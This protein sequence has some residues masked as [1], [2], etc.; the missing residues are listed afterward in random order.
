MHSTTIAVDLAKSVFEVA[1][2]QRPGKVETRHRLSRGQFSRF[3]AE[4]AP[5]TV[6]MEACGTAHFWGRE[7]QARGH[8]VVLLPPHAVRPYVTRNKTDGADAKGLLEALRNDDVRP[9]PV[10]SVDQH[11]LASLHRL[12]S[13]WMATRTARLNTLRGLLRELGFVIPLGARQVL[14]RVGELVSDADSGLPDALRPVLAETAR[15][16]RELE[17][18]VREVERSLETM[19]RGSEILVRLRTIPGVGLLTATA[20]GAF[21][22][23][24]ARFPSGRHFASYLGLTPRESSSG[25]RRRLGA[26]SKRGDPYLRMLLIHGAR[27]VLLHAKKPSARPDRLRTWALERERARG[28]NKAAVALANKLARIVWAVWRREHAYGSAIPTRE[29]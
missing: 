15:E 13:G 25:L 23:D 24:V 26:I 16:I 22:G 28:H 12:R 6:V 1:V 4:Q 18:R 5:A 7:A 14:P 11:V 8:R 17:A 29:D 20:L 9:V 27:A 21:V 3:L 10:K 19:A 2:S